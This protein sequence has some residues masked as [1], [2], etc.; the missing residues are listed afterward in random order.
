ML[1]PVTGAFASERPRMAQ[2]YSPLEQK[3]PL[4]IPFSGQ[5]FRRGTCLHLSRSLQGHPNLGEL[6]FWAQKQGLSCVWHEPLEFTE[7]YS[8]TSTQ[9]RMSD[10]ELQRYVVDLFEQ[11]YRRRAQDIH[12]INSGLSTRIQMRILGDLVNVD[13][14]DALFGEQLMSVLYNYFAQQTGSAVFSRL[15]RL[16]GRIVNPR[17]LPQGV[18][19]V[20]L[21]AEPIQ[22]ASP[23]AGILMTLRLLYDTS[24]A[25]GSLTERLQALGFFPEQSERIAQLTLSGGLTV[26]SG[27]T[28]HGKSTVL[29]HIFEA[30]VEAEPHKSFLSVEDPPEYTLAGVKQIQVTSSEVT[31]QS[32]RDQLYRDALAGALRSDP[33]VLMIGEIRTP[34]ACEAAVTGALTGQAVW[35]TLHARDAVSSVSRLAGLLE[36]STQTARDLLTDPCILS[37]ILHQRL[38]PVLCPDCK[39]PFAEKGSHQGAQGL[40]HRLNKAL[41][42]RL[43]SVCVRGPGCATCAGRGVFAMTVAAE[44][45]I[46]TQE[47]RRFFRLQ[48]PEEV[49]RLFRTEGSLSV[50][51]VALRK[52]SQGEVDPLD[53]EKRLQMP[54]WEEN[55]LS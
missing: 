3:Q 20:R 39:R 2:E 16:D 5:V 40:C 49:R 14:K 21:H 23:E 4:F 33:D 51:E 27:A 44:V 32:V 53:A 28:G 47:M 45:L 10:N 38:L 31:E 41:Q 12:V 36:Q 18:F 7:K 34:E 29:K 42:G 22:S 37:A 26:I 24:R 25:E 35:A 9:T 8:R 48:R 30:M 55:E 15:Q 43:A 11:A 52:I 13:L 54:L 46:L 6:W 19:A 17:V 1:R 50:R